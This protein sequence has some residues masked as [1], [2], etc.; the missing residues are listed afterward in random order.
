MLGTVNMLDWN[1]ETSSA[2]YAKWSDR[3]Q[4][5]INKVGKPTKESPGAN[6]RFSYLVS[7]PNNKRFYGR[8]LNI[9]LTKEGRFQFA[10]SHSKSYPQWYVE[11]VSK[12]ISALYEAFSQEGFMY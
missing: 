6:Y 1:A 7:N 2:Q 9:E 11:E 4:R 12:K 10:N 5:L 8:S 3:A